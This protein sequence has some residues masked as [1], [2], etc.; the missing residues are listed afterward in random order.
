MVVVAR[1]TKNS[2]TRIRRLTLRRSAA[3]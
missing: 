2:G 3:P 1:K